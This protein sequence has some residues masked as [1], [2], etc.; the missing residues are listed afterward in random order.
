MHLCSIGGS[1]V[2]AIFTNSTY[3]DHDVHRLNCYVSHGISAGDFNATVHSGSWDEDLKEDGWTDAHPQ[4][5]G[6]NDWTFGD[7][8]SRIDFTWAKG[9]ER[10]G[11][12][13]I[14]SHAQAHGVGSKDYSDHRGMTRLIDY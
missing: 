11:L 7:G 4:D 5:D 1:V 13:H 2:T 3:H 8:S 6:G 10:I 12:K 9:Q 14:V